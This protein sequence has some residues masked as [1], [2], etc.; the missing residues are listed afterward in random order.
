MWGYG[1]DR[2]GLGYGQVADI[3]ECVNEPSDTKK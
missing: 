3:C 1:L 2:V